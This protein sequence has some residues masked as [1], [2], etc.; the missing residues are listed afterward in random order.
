MDRNGIQNLRLSGQLKEEREAVR[1]L[2]KE[3]GAAI[4]LA[5]QSFLNMTHQIYISPEMVLISTSIYDR[6]N[7]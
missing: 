2:E 1:T 4:W 7:S 3:K 5:L 6:Q